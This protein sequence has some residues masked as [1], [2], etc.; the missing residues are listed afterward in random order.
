M[1]DKLLSLIRKPRFKKGVFISCAVIFFL[2]ILFFSFRNIVLRS[3]IRSK[4]EKFNN[5]YPA[6]LS[7]A[8]AS[9]SGFTTINLNG[10][11]LIPDKKDTLLSCTSVSTG[12]RFFPLLLGNI[13]ISDMDITGTM[14]NLVSKDSTDNFSFLLSRKP[15]TDSSAVANYST[16]LNKLTNAVFN[17]IPGQFS[18]KSFVMKI[19]LDSNLMTVRLN[20]L[21]MED[22]KFVSSINIEE[23]KKKE[24]LIAEGNIDKSN[25]TL[26]FR[27]YADKGKFTLPLCKQRWGLV[28]SFDTLNVGIS[29]NTY[30]DNEFQLQGYASAEGLVLN[31]RRIS[32]YDVKMEKAGFDFQFHVGTDFIE[33]DSSS[34]ITYN[35][36][37]LNPYVLYKHATAKQL[38]LKINNEFS[39]QDFF[40]S[41]PE[42]LFTNFNG[43]KTEGRL[44][45]YVNFFVDMNQPDSLT[46]D[47]YLKGKDF[48]VTKYGVTDFAMISGP[49]TFTAYENGNPV[50]SFIIGDDN[51]EFTPLNDIATY[52]K[53]AI[54]VSEN[55]GYYFSTGFD[56]GSLRLALIDDIKQKRFVRGGSTI[57][58]QLVRNVFLNKNK[59]MARKFEELLIV[60][61]MQTGD[62]C[63]KDRMYEVYL[64]VVEWGPGIYGISEA[65]EYYFRKR[66]S[67]LSVAESIFLASILPRPKWFKYSFDAGGNLITEQNQYYFSNIASLLLA[68]SIITE[69]DTFNLL[70][71]VKLK[72]DSRNY[73]EKDT[74]NYKLDPLKMMEGE[75]Q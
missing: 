45:L 42:G 15:K 63:N 57:E 22:H 66:P 21:S 29:R 67:Q 39:A 16:H 74:A 38:T 13:V 44:R 10:I 72:G 27:L 55:G 7:I 69:R 65:S 60:W 41:L 6:K 30:K 59:T 20:D 46:F 31:H 4:I 8:D 33:L 53:E 12:L 3:I 26:G 11:L 64:N 19:A 32:L 54:L 56:V 71:K 28:F 52:L 49:F 43:I 47:A 61:L 75:M 1:K 37:S 17:L 40:S 9:F 2:F 68:K 23:N 18:L 14:V 62:L 25:R 73:L 35:K 36:L 48:K 34:V 50:K 24:T 51:P 58:M 5:T 70:Q